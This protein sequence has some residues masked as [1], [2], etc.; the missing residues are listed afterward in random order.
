MTTLFGLLQLHLQLNN[1]KDTVQN[2]KQPEQPE[3]TNVVEHGYNTVYR[4]EHKELGWGVYL[5]GG[6]PFEAGYS[7]VAER[8]PVPYD[9]SLLV[10]NGPKDDCGDLHIKPEHFFGFS[11]KE[12]LRSWLYED[13]F[14]INLHDKGFVLKLFIVPSEHFF[15]GHTQVI[16]VRK[17]AISSTEHSLLEYFNLSRK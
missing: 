4:I 2:T 13:V 16:F 11:S 5:A 1:L 7:E 10:Q 17:E 3:Q 6:Y 12:Q 15:L 8:H 9:D 14:L